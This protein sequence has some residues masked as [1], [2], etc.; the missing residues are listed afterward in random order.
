MSENLFCVFI[1]QVVHEDNDVANLLFVH[2]RIGLAEHLD[3]VSFDGLFV[4]RLT[5]YGG[6]PGLDGNDRTLHG[7]AFDAF[8]CQQFE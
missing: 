8:G 4:K 6:S 3:A 2:I 7:M 5:S 1:K